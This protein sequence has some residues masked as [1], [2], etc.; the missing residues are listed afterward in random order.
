M[1]IADRR[2]SCAL[3]IRSRVVERCQVVLLI[4]LGGEVHAGRKW[5]VGRWLG[6]CPVA[7]LH[8]EILRDTIVGHV[9]FA[10][11]C[12]LIVKIEI[13]VIFVAF[14]VS[15]LCTNSPWA[16][17]ENFS[18]QLQVHIVAEGKVVATIAQIEASCWF[19][20]ISRHDKAAWICACDREIGKRNSQRKRH[21][22]YNE[23]CRAR[24]DTL[25][26]TH[27]ASWHGNVEVRM[28]F[29]TCRV[30]SSSHVNLIVG[31]FLWRLCTQESIL[32][33]RID[34]VDESLFRVKVVWHL[35][36]LVFF[37]SF[38]E[39]GQAELVANR[40]QAIDGMYNRTVH[41][42]GHLLGCQL[43]VQILHIGIAI[44]KGVLRV[45]EHS[46][47]VFCLI[48]D[49]SF[50]RTLLFSFADRVLY[51]C[52]RVIPLLC[53][54]SFIYLNAM[55]TV[56]LNLHGIQHGCQRVGHFH[57]CRIASCAYGDRQCCGRVNTVIVGSSFRLADPFHVESRHSKCCDEHKQ[58]C[59]EP[60]YI[61]KTTAKLII[62]QQIKRILTRKKAVLT[63]SYLFSLSFCIIPK[64]SG[65][66]A[67]KE[68]ACWCA[69]NR[70][71]GDGCSVITLQGSA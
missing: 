34:V 48:Y 18:S 58:R 22:F 57:C 53:S 12:Y 69:H 68:I 7:P 67:H 36:R 9:L 44:K 51:C 71:Y 10:S 62:F 13:A 60:F 66:A 40:V 30:S 70:N 5:T 39:D 35:F 45:H 19:I 24:K 52:N 41:V 31:S 65:F 17:R 59:C 56:K 54:S 20:A 3:R 37:A 6:V 32:L 26:W 29:V 64:F 47:W 28:L 42:H 46:H 43:N 61:H 15:C 11:L 4:R 8:F 50:E 27:F 14:S 23:P 21:V 49:W 16:F 33:S 2:S 25:S 63:S 38:F 1:W 55:L